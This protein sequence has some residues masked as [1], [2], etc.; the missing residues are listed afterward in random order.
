[1][2]A[3]FGAP[4]RA[5]SITRRDFN[6]RAVQTATGL[7]LAAGAAPAFS[8]ASDDAAKTD[9]PAR[10]PEQDAALALV[11]AAAPYLPEADQ[12]ELESQ[13]N[14]VI[15]SGERLRAHSVPE[16]HEPDF[17]FRADVAEPRS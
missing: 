12:A 7:L 15:T 9:V 2:S 17:I 13:V 3:S 8:A 4:G 14:S 5:G 1:M 16:G 11:R 10:T 6:R